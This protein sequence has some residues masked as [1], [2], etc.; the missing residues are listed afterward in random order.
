MRQIQSAAL[1]LFEARGFGS[2]TVEEI[3]AAAEVSP[4]TIYRQFGTKEQ[5]VLW[6]EYDPL[7]FAAIRDRL[8]CEA[9]LEAVRNGL[10]EMLDEIYADDAA[11]IRRRTRL[12]LASPALEAANAAAIATMRG[13]LAKLFADASPNLDAVDAELLSAIL[14]ASLEVS[15]RRWYETGDASLAAIFD[16]AFAR[17]GRLLG[18]RRP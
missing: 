2:V 6:D 3:A 5:L 14:V 16:D 9:P 17:L 18:D 4:P 12:L 10:V 8:K 11:R 13:G 15:V 7:L 1:D